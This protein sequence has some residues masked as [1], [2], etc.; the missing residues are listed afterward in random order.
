M[1]LFM[2]VCYRTMASTFGYLSKCYKS[3]LDKDMNYTAQC[4]TGHQVE[5]NENDRCKIYTY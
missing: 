2:S 1:S 4:R 5:A 3:F